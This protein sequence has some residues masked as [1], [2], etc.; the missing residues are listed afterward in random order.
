MALCC[1]LG[2]EGGKMEDQVGN[3][4][5][6]SRAALTRQAQGIELTLLSLGLGLIVMCLKHCLK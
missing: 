3:D 2:R 6:V 1:L 5:D 4:K